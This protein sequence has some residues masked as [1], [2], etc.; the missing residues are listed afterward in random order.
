MQYHKHKI[1]FSTLLAFFFLFNTSAFSQK[2]ALKIKGEVLLKFSKEPLP[3]AK[4][5]I[6]GNNFSAITNENGVFSIDIN[7]TEIREKYI[8]LTAE[9]PGHTFNVLTIDWLNYSDSPLKIYGETNYAP[10]PEGKMVT[11]KELIEPIHPGMTF[12]YFNEYY[13]LIIKEYL[14]N[15]GKP[16]HTKVSGDTNY[17]NGPGVIQTYTFKDSLLIKYHY[18]CRYPVDTTHY[19]YSEIYKYNKKKLLAERIKSNADGD[20]HFITYT[21]DSKGR[22]KEDKDVFE[23][24]YLNQKQVTTIKYFYEPDGRIQKKQSSIKKIR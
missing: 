7:T 9:L 12:P 17:I 21:Y 22:L 24:K 6:P 18:V 16:I 4:V 14:D 8:L 3:F 5:Y 10:W 23:N 11:N 13:G 20:E 1:F 19:Y 15:T 2:K